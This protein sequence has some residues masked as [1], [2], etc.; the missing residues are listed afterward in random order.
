[1]NVPVV[2][3]HESLEAKSQVEAIAA[4]E[5]ANEDFVEV[6]GSSCLTCVPYMPA[7]APG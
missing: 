5:P 7:F 2:F 1:M 3:K 4:L 6:R